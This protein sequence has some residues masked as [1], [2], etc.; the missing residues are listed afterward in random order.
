MICFDPAEAESDVRAFRGRTAQLILTSTV[1]VYTKYPRRY[2]ITEDEAYGAVN[3]YGINKV[4]S[5]EIIAT[6][7]R[8]GDFA[9]TIIRPAHTYGEGRGLISSLG[10]GTGYIDRIRKGKPIVVHGDGTSLWC[11]CHVDDVG[12]AYVNA[13]GNPKAMN[14]AYHVTG[15]EWMTWNRYHQGVAEAMRAPL[16]R[17]VHIPT[18][19]LAM[20]AKRGHIC[21]ENFQFDNIFDNTRARADLAFRYTIPW[22]EGVRRTVSWL[23]AHGKVDNSDDD[24]YEDRLIAAWERLGAGMLRELAGLD[25]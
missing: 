14:Q 12:R 11:S 21:I 24:P 15:E 4:R 8:R 6:A 17:L 13:I 3:T 18:D 19:V 23:D 9:S 1:D 22:V 25:D 2:P 16:P 10:W 20:V 5:E 7:G